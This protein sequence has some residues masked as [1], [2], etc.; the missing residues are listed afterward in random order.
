M[1]VDILTP[2]ATYPDPT[3]QTALALLVPYLSVFEPAITAMPVEVD[4]PDVNNPLALSDVAAMSR[5]A[6][7]SSREVSRQISKRLTELTERAGVRA[8]LTPLRSQPQDLAETIAAAARL[9]DLTAITYDATGDTRAI[10][11]AALFSSGRPVLLFPSRALV[12]TR[13]DTV[14]IAWDGSRAAARALHDA[15]PWLQRAARIVVIAVTGEKDL[16]DERGHEVVAYLGRIGLHATVAAAEL[17]D[18]SV[19]E[20]LQE[21]A[22]A[23]GATLMVMGAFGHNRVRDFLL[24]GATRSVLDKLLLPVL[25]SY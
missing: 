23:Q 22:L 12:E 19:G 11:E 20:A 17:G 1:P 16:A 15:R 8:T 5:E 2:L 7:A 21:L 6:E 18:V 25:L 4:I 3:D 14:A 13:P 24:G 9:H 10:A